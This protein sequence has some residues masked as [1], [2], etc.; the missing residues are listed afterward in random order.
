MNAMKTETLL[1]AEE[2]E[3]IGAEIR[4]IKER[5]GLSW[6]QLGEQAEMA[7]QT[8]QAVANGTYAGDMQ[9]MARRAK[10]WLDSRAAERESPVGVPAALPFVR[11]PFV[12]EIWIGLDYARV[13]PSI[14]LVV[15]DPG[16]SKTTAAREYAKATP[17]AHFINT[18]PSKAN[19][20]GLL[21]TLVRR[22]RIPA[23][24]PADYADAV[25]E[26]L[27]G[28]RSLLLI[29]EAQRLDAKALEQLR[30]LHDDY[31]VGVALLGNETLTHIINKMA[32]ERDGAQFK[33]RVGRRVAA[34]KPAA[35]DVEAFVA[36]AALDDKGMQDFLRA[37]AKRPGAF[38]L[39]AN[40][41]WN[42]QF[43]AAS[44]KAAL[45]LDHLKQ[46]FENLDFSI[47]AAQ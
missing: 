38:R 45:T 14:T 37:V 29:D 20:N 11:T 42:G 7:H 23:R 19:H 18:D 41:L 16:M 21:W 46:G 8:L 6:P 43:L 2:I 9:G 36:A 34:R 10:R 27:G 31:G 1:S 12:E 33:S 22:L 5:E 30:S 17:N 4:A 3:A 44:Q 39:A 24:N 32:R 47:G 35:Q 26:R 28:R 40:T 13:R 15:A 25:G